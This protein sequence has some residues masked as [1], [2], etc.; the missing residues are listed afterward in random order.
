MSQKRAFFSVYYDMNGT[1]IFI[2]LMQKLI[3]NTF[4][5]NALLE[6][7]YFASYQNYIKKDFQHQSETFKCLHP[8]MAVWKRNV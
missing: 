1:F 5:P 3:K 4:S 6:N 7:R 8:F 2:E